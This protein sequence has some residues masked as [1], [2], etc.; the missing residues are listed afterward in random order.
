MHLR[1]KN[2]VSVKK[3]SFYILFFCIVKSL[4]IGEFC[5]FYNISEELIFIKKKSIGIREW[6]VFRLAMGPIC[7]LFFL[8]SIKIDFFLNRQSSKCI[9]QLSITDSRHG[10]GLGS[11]WCFFLLKKKIYG[12]KAITWI[13][14]LPMHTIIK[15]ERWH[16]N[17]RI[18]SFFLFRV[19]WPIFPIGNLWRWATDTCIKK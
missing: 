13:D 7:L 5:G 18:F 6:G 11:K 3:A 1:S 15:G 2:K 17:N 10:F 14:I 16:F 4:N 12:S 8:A 19:L 9:Q